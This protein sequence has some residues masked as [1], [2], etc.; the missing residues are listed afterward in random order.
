MTLACTSNISLPLLIQASGI[1]VQTWYPSELHVQLLLSNYRRSLCILNIDRLYKN[2]SIPPHNRT[3][4]ATLDIGHLTSQSNSV[5]KQ[6]VGISV[7]NVLL[8]SQASDEVVS[9]TTKVRGSLD[10]V[11]MGHLV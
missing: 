4:R 2:P 1:Q 11:E 5:S 8:G 6:S 10:L 3:C 7:V 9:V